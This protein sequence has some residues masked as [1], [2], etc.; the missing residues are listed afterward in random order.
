MMRKSFAH[1][2]NLNV[3]F[4]FIASF[5]LVAALAA[6]AQ[7]TGSTRRL[8]PAVA[9]LCAVG[10]WRSSGFSGH[11]A[12]ERRNTSATSSR[13][14]SKFPQGGPLY[15]ERIQPLLGRDCG[16]EWRR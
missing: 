8:R 13:R 3:V 11:R 12:A 9:T 16:R 15:N 2:C 5:T 7:E 6:S 10:D 4:L 1:I 14:A